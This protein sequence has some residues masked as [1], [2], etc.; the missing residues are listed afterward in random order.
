[1]ADTSSAKKGGLTRG[2]AA[3]IGVLSIVLL[4]VV[5]TRYGTSRAAPGAEPAGYVPRRPVAVAPAT[6]TAAAT[7]SDKKGQ[8]EKVPIAAIAAAV[9][10]AKWKS[11]NLSEVVDYD[12]FALPPA[13]PKPPVIDVAGAN[14]ADLVAAAEADDAKQ[15]ADALAQSNMQLE[16]LKQRGVQVIVRERDQYVAMIGDRTVHVGDEIDGFTITKIDPQGVHVERKG[17]Q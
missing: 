7:K 15:M 6:T 8:S 5:Y 13:F 3:L 12:P 9:D 1:V 17:A 10:E 16:E 11:P 2:K 14:G 4:G